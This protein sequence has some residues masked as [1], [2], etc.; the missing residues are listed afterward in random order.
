MVA[1]N[2][3]KVYFKKK[4]YKVAEFT[5][6][7]CGSM[8]LTNENQT[9]I[10]KLLGVTQQGLSYKMKHGTFTLYETIVLL[11]HFDATDKEII[12]IMRM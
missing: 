12:H 4:E 6:W 7:I 10:G 3:P 11:A 9:D 8:K 5:K 2:M 1:T